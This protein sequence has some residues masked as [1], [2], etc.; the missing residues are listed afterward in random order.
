[1]TAGYVEQTGIVFEFIFRHGK[2]SQA[3]RYV[4]PDARDI[5]SACDSIIP[6]LVDFAK[7]QQRLSGRPL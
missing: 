4:F 2:S 5:R 6:D 7:R 3:T 1:M